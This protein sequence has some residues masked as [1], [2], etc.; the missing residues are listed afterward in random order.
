MLMRVWVEVGMRS[1]VCLL[2]LFVAACGAVVLV[3][4]GFAQDGSYRFQ[5]QVSENTSL[6][7]MTYRDVPFGIVPDVRYDSSGRAVSVRIERNGRIGELTSILYDWFSGYRSLGDAEIDNAQRDE[8]ERQV[9]NRSR[10]LK[11]GYNVADG[12][13]KNFYFWFSGAPLPSESTQTILAPY[14]KGVMAKCPSSLQKAGSASDL[15]AA[16]R[17]VQARDPFGEPT[18]REILDALRGFVK[19][20]LFL[21]FAELKKTSC[22]KVTSSVFRCRFTFRTSSS[23]CRANPAACAVGDLRKSEGSGLF[24]RGAVDWTFRSEVTSTPRPAKQENALVEGCYR[25]CMSFSSDA[26]SC[27][28]QCGTTIH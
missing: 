18:D 28:F 1:I 19:N 10:T 25:A 14:I 21:D 16:K 27:A 12:F 23:N 11:C 20:T 22:Q 15:W 9:G 5:P 6:I 7:M 4:N 17:G 8:F 13:E 3:A 24:E 26:P 2:R